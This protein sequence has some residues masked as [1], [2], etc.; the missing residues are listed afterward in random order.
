M[1]RR[2]INLFMKFV[3]HKYVIAGT[4]IIITD[5]EGR[6]LLGKRTKEA[7]FYSGLW[8]LPGG[9]IEYGEKI[10]NTAIREIKEELDVEIKVIKNT[11]PYESLPDKNCHFHTIGIPVYAKIIKGT[12]KPKD[13]T[14][15]VKWFK[16][17][18]IKKIN[19]AYN[20]KEILIKE[21]LI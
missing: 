3:K 17:N 16:P 8:G 5:S 10:E 14:S 11:K 18:E 20:H 9:L 21:G 6:I 7:I 13:E 4:P 15:E 1:I 19:L 2:I 12:P